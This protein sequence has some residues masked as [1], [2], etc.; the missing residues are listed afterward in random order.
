MNLQFKI[1]FILI[2]FMLLSLLSLGMWSF[3]EAREA[4][5]QSTYRYM[6]IVLDSY[7]NEHVRQNYQL[8]KNANLEKIKSGV[9][10]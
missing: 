5:Y 10:P 7:T 1:L 6:D 2:P 4:T 3:N 9:K 8:L